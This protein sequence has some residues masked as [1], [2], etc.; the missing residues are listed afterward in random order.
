MISTRIKVS[1][2]RHML[3]VYKNGRGGGLYFHKKGLNGSKIYVPLNNKQKQEFNAKYRIRA[4]NALG[5]FY[6]SITPEE[7]AFL[8]R[9][10][11]ERL[12]RKNKK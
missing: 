12:R 7:L 2:G 10:L 1:N 4:V 9:V 3:V 5:P 11:K 8:E 6:P